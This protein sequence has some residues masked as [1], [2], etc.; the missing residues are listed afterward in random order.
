MLILQYFGYTFTKKI[1]KSFF[2]FLSRNDGITR[3]FNSNHIF[4]QHHIKTKFQITIFK[5]KGGDWKDELKNKEKQKKIKKQNP[6]T[7]TNG[8]KTVK[9]GFNQMECQQCVSLCCSCNT[10]KIT[11]GKRDHGSGGFQIN[12]K[13]GLSIN[14]EKGILMCH[15]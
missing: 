7:I 2:F 10:K 9:S 4:F 15:K 6:T 14:C 11:S 8:H 13:V 5:K 1:S 3:L 12:Y